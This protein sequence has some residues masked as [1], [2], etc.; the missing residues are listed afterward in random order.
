MPLSAT[1]IQAHPLSSTSTEEEEEGEGEGG[2][3]GRGRGWSL[4]VKIQGSPLT[5]QHAQH[6]PKPRFDESLALYHP[7]LQQQCSVHP[8]HPACAQHSAENCPGEGG[9]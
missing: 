2:E 5:R 6:R 3:E 8:R 1:E 7:Y 9:G 4:L